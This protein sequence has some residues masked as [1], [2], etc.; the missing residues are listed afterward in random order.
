MPIK[1]LVSYKLYIFTNKGMGG[2]ISEFK[3]LSYKSIN[4][5]EIYFSS[6]LKC[7]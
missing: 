4:N 2:C 7:S 6:S 5:C 1:N 3:N